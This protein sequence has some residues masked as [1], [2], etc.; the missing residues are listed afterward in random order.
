MEANPQSLQHQSSTVP[1]LAEILAFG[2]ERGASQVRR[3]V[4]LVQ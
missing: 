4:V 2:S 1:L 3:E